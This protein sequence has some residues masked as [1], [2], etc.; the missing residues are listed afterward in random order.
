[1]YT[2]SNKKIITGINAANATFCNKKWFLTAVIACRRLV[3]FNYGQMTGTAPD[4]KG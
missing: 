3:C 1:M 4:S 2:I